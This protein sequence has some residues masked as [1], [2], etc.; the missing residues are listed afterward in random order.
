MIE[1]FP[2]RT[3]FLSILNFNIHWY[4]VLYLFSFLVG[5]KLI[6]K[7]QRFRN[8]NLSE[9]KWGSILT[10]I[11]LG[12]LIGGRLGFV[13]LYEPLYFFRHPFEIFAV[14]KGGMASHGGF[15]AVILILFWICK[16]EKLSPLAFGDLIVIPVAIGLAFGRVGNFI[17]YELYGSVTDVAWAIDIPGVSGPRHPTQLYAVAK[18][19]WIALFCYMHL[20]TPK[21]T[22]G[23]TAALFLI[24]YAILRFLVEFLRIQDYDLFDLGVISLTRG[25]LYSIPIFIFGLVAWKWSK[26]CSK[27]TSVDAYQKDHLSE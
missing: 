15:L 24:M 2:S 23:I 21:S 10:T 20:R 3:V 6:Q 18:N 16:K 8:I 12:V 14:W 1:V 17:N 5:Y 26:G 11:I 4:G 19:L 13:L 22:P 27:E 9:E 25:Q 7:L